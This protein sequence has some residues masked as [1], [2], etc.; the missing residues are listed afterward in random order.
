MQQSL[1]SQYRSANLTRWKDIRMANDW[2]VNSWQDHKIIQQPKYCDE[3]EY[4]AVL[5]ELRTYPPLVQ[6]DDILRLRHK[7]QQ[8]AAGKAFILQAGDCAEM[9]SDCR[10]DVVQSKLALLTAMA[11]HLAGQTSEAGEEQAAKREVITIGRIA[12]QYAKPRSHRYIT[13]KGQ[14]IPNYFGDAVNSIA[15]DQDSR[16]P[17]P[18]NLIAAYEHAAKTLLYMRRTYPQ[19]FTSHEGL[20]LA[21]EQTQ[22]RRFANDYYDCSG[23]MLWVGAR[24]CALDSAQVEL[25]R[26]VNNPIGVKVGANIAA[27]E[28][29]AIVRRLRQTVDKPIVVIVRLGKDEVAAKLPRLIDACRAGEQQ[30]IWMVDPMHGNTVQR[31]GIKTRCFD[32]ICAEIEMS[33]KVH[34]ELGSYLGGVHLEIA[35]SAVTECIGGKSALTVSDLSHR[36]ESGCDPRLN[37]EQSLELAE[38]VASLI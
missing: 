14:T 29:V 34:R 36:Y 32:D 16:Q 12:G 33:C 8:V 27:A 11:K 38:F 6:V 5:Q 21:Y 18:R 30:V 25:L 3:Q 31:L 37:R 10:E 9:F 17:K 7:L 24:C 35:S 22:V 23:H 20:L 2:Q 1:E 19:I 4:A 15:F 13:H 26:G 28:L